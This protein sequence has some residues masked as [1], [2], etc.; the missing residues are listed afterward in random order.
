MIWQDLNQRRSFAWEF[1]S[2][3]ESHVE[4]RDF[5][6]IVLMSMGFNHL[7]ADTMAHKTQTSLALEIEQI[8]EAIIN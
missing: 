8:E 7:S 6:P 5:L 2:Y 3:P 4:L 1:Q